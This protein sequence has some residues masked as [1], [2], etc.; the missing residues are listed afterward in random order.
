[1]EKRERKLK[2]FGRRRSWKRR[3][4]GEAERDERGE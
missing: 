2:R 4:L 3:E 1:M